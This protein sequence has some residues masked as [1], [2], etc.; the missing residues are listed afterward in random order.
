MHVFPSKLL[1]IPRS[2]T[3][4]NFE[5]QLF[6]TIIKEKW[7]TADL[8]EHLSVKCAGGINEKKLSQPEWNERR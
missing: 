3:A 4:C 5:N 6:A 7:L 8:K 1:Y 2:V